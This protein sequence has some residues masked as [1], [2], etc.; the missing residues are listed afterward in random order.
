[1]RWMKQRAEVAVAAHTEPSLQYVRYHSASSPAPNPSSLLPNAEQW[2]EKNLE[3]KLGRACIYSAFL[4]KLHVNFWILLRPC[5]IASPLKIKL[6]EAE[7][8][9]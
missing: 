6:M 7:F 9:R 4:V 2:I 5:R 1:M 3:G 8:V